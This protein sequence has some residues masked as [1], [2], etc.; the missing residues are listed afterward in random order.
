M[1][2][3]YLR[4]HKL[5][6]PARYDL[7]GS[8][9]PPVSPNE[10]FA[11]GLSVSLEAPG[12]YGHPD[13]IAAVAELYRVTPDRVVLVPGTS[14]ANFIALAVSARRGSRVL[15]E[16]P[17]YD[18]ILRAARF[19]GM[20]VIPLT[21]RSEQGFGVP[22]DQLEADLEKGAA[23]VVLTNLHNPSG[24][25]LSLAT[26][27]ELVL[28]CGRANATLIMDEVY[29]DGASIIG[30]EARWTAAAL[31]DHC[32]ATGSLTKVYG[33]GGLRTGW[34]LGDPDTVWRAQDI[35]DL[36]SVENVAPAASLALHALA[37]L[38]NL[39][40]RYRRF[41]E[42]GQAA[43][44]RWLANEPLISGYD[45][46]G[47]LFEWIRLPDGATGDDVSKLL[48]SEFDTQVVPGRF[49]GSNDHI[50]I[51]TALAPADLTDALAHISAAVSKSI[52]RRA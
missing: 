42:E 14:S 29:L 8:G 11:D 16:R 23:A 31:A 7:T 12:R 1:T 24:N 5:H 6:R 13:L 20:E 48:A 33:L 3:P 32:I 51:S 45:N 34:L 9:V 39:E 27:S 37:N 4:W 21:R 35:M 47:A 38:G 44:R 26:V 46:H 41:Y 36:L 43:F 19:L 49:F 52:N 2:V 50:R 25:R 40:E 18:P 10:V 28:M 15:V 30:R 22:L 17:C